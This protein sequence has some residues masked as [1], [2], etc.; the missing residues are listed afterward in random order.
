MSPDQI[1]TNHQDPYRRTR[2][3]P[4]ATMMLVSSLL[5]LGMTLPERRPLKKCRLP[6]CTRQTDHNGG[7]CSAAHH[8]KHNLK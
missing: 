4:L 7:Y 2:R 3:T 8:A 1:P 6:D 5:G